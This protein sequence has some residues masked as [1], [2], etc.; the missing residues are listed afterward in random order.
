M[1]DLSDFKAP[2]ISAPEI[3]KAADDFRAK[4]GQ[5][6]IPVDIEGIIEFDLQI[7]IL[8]KAD[9]YSNCGTYA[10]LSDDCKVIRVDREHFFDS[11]SH[12]MVRF[13]LAHEI[14]HYILHHN[15][16]PLIRPAS[17]VEW[18][19]IVTT[20]PEDQYGSMEYHANEFA[21]RLLV[22]PNELIQEL[23]Q[24]KN[25]INAYYEQVPDMMDDIVI[26]YVAVPISRTFKV[27]EQ[28]IARRIKF[29]KLWGNFKP[30]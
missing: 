5:N 18:K 23:K 19:N 9:V 1:K 24:Y 26:D 27:S 2:F 15:L 28:V 25:K 11:Y 20:M 7:E 14:G 10:F 4:Y 21:G 29:E 16:V 8:P 17:I 6:K 12:P 30:R 13:S 3:R 22:P